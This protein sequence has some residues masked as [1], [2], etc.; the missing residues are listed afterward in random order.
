MRILLVDDDR[1]LIN[2]LQISLGEYNYV[3]DAVTDGEQ[4]WIYG[5]T[6]TY[7]LI[8]LDWSVPQLDGI[9][10]C[11]RFRNDGYHLPILLLTAPNS[12][13]DKIRGL[14]AGAD[15]C[16]DKP[17][18]IQ[19]LTARIRAL[20]RRSNFNSFSSLSWGDL[21]LELH[22]C[23]VTYRGQILL[24]TAKEY[25]LL[26]LFLRH[27]QKVF[28]V[29]EIIQSLWTSVEYPTEATVRSHLRRLRL[30]LKLAGLAEDPIVTVRGRGYCLKS[31]PENN[32]G[33]RI[34]STVQLDTQDHKRGLHLAAL[35]LAWQKYRLKS[36]QQLAVLESTL[37]AINEGTFTQGDCQTA[38]SIAHSLAGN[39]GLFGFELG[40]QLAQ[41]LEQLLQKNL[42]SEPAQVFQFQTILNTLRQELFIQEN[43]SEQ[44]SRKLTE[45]SPLLLIVNNDPKF[46]KQLTQEA[47][48]QGIQTAISRTPE[49]ARNLLESQPKRQLPQAAILKIPFA[50]LASHGTSLW[51]YLSLIAEFKLHSPSIPVLVIADSDRLQDRLLVARHGACLYIKQ[52]VT[53]RQ[54]LSFCQ[55][56]LESSARGKKIMIVDDNVELLQVLT[57]LLQPWQFKLTTLDDPRQF[58][59]VLEAVN[60]NLLILDIE[61]P[62]LSGIELYRV[63]QTHPYWCKLPV[64]FLTVHK[65]VTIRE[66]VLTLGADDFIN[67][68]VTGKQLADRILNRLKSTEV[69][70]R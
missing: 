54:A 51:E 53:P 27:S 41:E 18:Q 10:L 14:D 31:F 4:G 65:D 70:N 63:L 8:I 1:N 37:K 34:T 16:L 55:Q 13:E 45:D 5:S 25:G 20:L 2:Q 7:D 66:Q 35:N 32:N 6:Y 60:P 17:F 40:S 49:Q 43:I 23:Q 48:G 33:D 44:I 42:I 62:Y 52:P 24:L 59:D 68:P 28:S 38:K 19:E 22:T 69:K 61:M 50:K 39:L 64:L 15:D 58:W 3:L 12:I 57:S 47:S 9:S 46:T 30:K 11:Q 29:E 67:K 36:D 26:E 56:F 21:Q